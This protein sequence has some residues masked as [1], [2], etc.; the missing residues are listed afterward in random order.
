MKS[1]KEIFSGKEKVLSFEFFPPKK[2]DLLK[3]TENLM[4][5]L[6]AFSP[7]F[8]T[9][10]YGAGGGTREFSK[11]LV[12]FIKNSLDIPSVHHLTCVGHNKNEI[13]D[14]VTSLKKNGI[15]HILAL[16]GD[17]PKGQST[18]ESI[19]GGFS[20]AR[21][22]TEFLSTIGDLSL[23]VAG[24][25]EGHPDANSDDEE[26]TYLKSKVDAGAELIIT[27]LFFEERKYFSFCERAKIAGIK[28][29]ILPGIMPIQNVAQLERFTSMCGASIPSSLLSDLKKIEHNEEAVLEYGIEFGVSL[30]KKLLNG[31]APGVHLYTLNKSRQITPIVDRI[32]T[33][34][35]ASSRT[36]EINSFET[37]N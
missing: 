24:Y 35:I 12:S 3:Q 17:P 11:H 36:D 22:L 34:L 21:E 23:A 9:V 6:S 37:A 2:S 5:E 15:K 28:V 20:S 26:M 30:I 1:F 8:M 14:I 13:S 19:P 18:V 33:D 4:T 29:P 10:T 32:A 7:H 16:R 25:P 27:Q 31:G